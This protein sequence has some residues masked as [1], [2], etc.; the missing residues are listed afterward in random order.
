MFL[1][2]FVTKG[3]VFNTHWNYDKYLSQGTWSRIYP[4]LRIGRDGH[5]DQ[6]YDI[7]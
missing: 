6:A 1:F 5:L 7:S 4:R 2:V 3:D